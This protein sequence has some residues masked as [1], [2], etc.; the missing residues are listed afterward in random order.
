MRIGELAQQTEVSTK[1]LR[2]Y[3]D[4][5]LLPDPGRTPS[6]YRD[7][8]RGT[9]DRVQFIRAAQTAGLTLRQIGQILSIRD[10]GTTPCSHVEQFVDQRLTEVERRIAELEQTRGR[11][12]ELARRARELDPADCG[13]LCDI[14]PHTGTDPGINPGINPGTD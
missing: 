8:D 4:E 11:L 9:V 13:G 7:Y 6:G 14:I 1:T 3:E 12:L 10:G 2:F 5:G